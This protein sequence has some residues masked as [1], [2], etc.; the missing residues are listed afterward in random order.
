VTLTNELPVIVPVLNIVV[1]AVALLII[2]VL[3]I[4]R[5]ANDRI[6][7][8]EATLWCATL[9]LL[10]GALFQANLLPLDWWIVIGSGGRIATLIGLIGLVTR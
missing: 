7:I 9:V 6:F 4:R 3:A 5:D 1:S 2:T 10:A 8:L